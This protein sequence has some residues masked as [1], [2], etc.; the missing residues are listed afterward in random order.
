MYVKIDRQKRV[1]TSK[2]IVENNFALQRIIPLENQS[3]DTLKRKYIENKMACTKR[4]GY[5]KN[6]EIEYAQADGAVKQSG[7]LSPTNRALLIKLIR[8]MKA[9]TKTSVLANK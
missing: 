9:E 8:E 2:Q 5:T 7:Q 1:K 6:E 3:D 4:V